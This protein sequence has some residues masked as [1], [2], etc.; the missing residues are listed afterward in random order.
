MT[1]TEE[2]VKEQRGR[3][4]FPCNDRPF[5]IFKLILILPGQGVGQTK[6]KMKTYNTEQI[7]LF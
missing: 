4:Y 6:H 2:I 1:G 3:S 7:F 5:A